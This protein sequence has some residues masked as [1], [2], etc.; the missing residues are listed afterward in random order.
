MQPTVTDKDPL[1]Y[2]IQPPPLKPSSPEEHYPSLPRHGT[3]S[4]TSGYN[5]YQFKS[6]S[7]SVN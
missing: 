3:Y 2:S 6:P 1:I 7:T 5:F 4:S